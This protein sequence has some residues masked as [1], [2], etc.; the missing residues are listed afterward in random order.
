MPPVT[1]VYL[2]TG[3][4]GSGK[5]TLAA[6]LA[7]AATRLHG[8]NVAIVDT[9]PQGSLGRWFMARTERMEVDEILEVHASSRRSGKIRQLDVL[10]G[11]LETGD[12]LIVM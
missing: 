6:H 4:L 10:L 2:I 11:S 8:K 1:R 9:D 5:T 7:V 12:A 3:F